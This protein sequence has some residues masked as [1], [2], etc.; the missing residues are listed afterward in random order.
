MQVFEI[1]F[2][3]CWLVLCSNSCALRHFH[4]TLKLTASSSSPKSI[5]T[6]SKLDILLRQ[7]TNAA[8]CRLLS[9][10]FAKPRHR[11]ALYAKER[12]HPINTTCGAPGGGRGEPGFTTAACAHAPTARVVQ[13]RSPPWNLPRGVFWWLSRSEHTKTNNARLDYSIMRFQ[14]AAAGLAVTAVGSVSG[15]VSPPPTAGCQR[16]SFLRH[17]PS[18]ARLV[19]SLPTPGRAPTAGAAASMSLKPRK[20]RFPLW[21]RPGTAGQGLERGLSLLRGA[22]A[23][24]E[25]DEEMYEYE[26]GEGEEY[27]GEEGLDRWAPPLVSKY[28]YYIATAA[29][30]LL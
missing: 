13:G 9:I 8:A 12:W 18:N 1:C 11:G 28:L 6:S 27:D 29:S 5:A 25:D 19:P 24:R 23:E 17:G 7:K 15:F 30:L 4:N 22:A 14:T 10:Y 3:R 26:D 20:Q 21:L 16:S 2:P